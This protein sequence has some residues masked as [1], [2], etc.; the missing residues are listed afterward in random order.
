MAW[1]GWYVDEHGM[2]Q[3]AQHPGDMPSTGSWQWGLVDLGS[4]MT[5]RV[6]KWV[7]DPNAPPPPAKPGTPGKS[8]TKDG[9]TT[10]GTST[11]APTAAERRAD[12]QERARKRA[13]RRASRMRRLRRNRHRARERL[14]R[15]KWRYRRARADQHLLR[16]NLVRR[17]H[18]TED[19]IATLSREIRRMIQ[20]RDRNRARVH[21]PQQPKFEGQVTVEMLLSTDGIS[22]GSSVA[23][24]PKHRVYAQARITLNQ[25]VWRPGLLA[26]PWMIRLLWNPPA[27]YSAQDN[28]GDGHDEYVVS[29]PVVI[30]R[31]FKAPPTKPTG[32][33]WSVR[34]ELYEIVLDGSVYDGPA[35][36]K[37]HLEGSE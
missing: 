6:Q 20:V 18:E 37:P 30:I 2:W 34:A 11:S 19:R 13:D 33:Q 28:L 5:T 3:T 26:Q 35:N 24:R 27:R 36:N 17:M 12:R 23:V 16:R 31:E 29:N 1:V 9:S 21:L 32:G 10:S 22:F 4:G 14:E 15:L 7:A 8:Q 25:R